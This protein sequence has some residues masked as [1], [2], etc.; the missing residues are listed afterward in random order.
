MPLHRPSRSRGRELVLA[1]GVL[2]CLLTWTALA[3]RALGHDTASHPAVLRLPAAHAIGMRVDTLLLG[4]YAHGSFADAVQTLSSDLSP[5]ERE[6]VGRHLERIF[7]DVVPRDELGDAGRLRVAYER[8]VRPDGTTRAIRVLSAEAA[9]AGEMHTAFYYERDGRPGYYDPFGRSLDEHEW[10]KPLHTALRITSGFTATRMHPILHR[11]LPH[12]GV[13]Y[14]G[15]IG[16]PVHATADGVVISAGPRGGYGNMVEVRHPNGY[17]TRYAHLSRIDPA[18][19]PGTQVRQGEVI[20][21]VGMTGMATGPHLHYE[22][23][24]NGHP[25]NPLR[26][27]AGSGPVR[28]I[29]ADSAWAAQ[30]MR[31]SRLLARTPREG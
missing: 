29:G 21:Y 28:Q 13:D 16:T 9:V 5:E 14:A 8:T 4:G 2:L 17:S 3:A 10:A 25:V 30:R 6:M 15:R 22:V 27:S 1:A 18:A 24:R 19:V 23:R 26:V 11:L 31:L 7:A 12:T 20:G